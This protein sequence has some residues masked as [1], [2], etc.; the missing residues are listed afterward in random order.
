MSGISFT[1]SARRARAPPAAEV[2][3]TSPS[4]T[5][6]GNLPATKCPAAVCSRSYQN[7][8]DEE[9]RRLQHVR[10][11]TWLGLRE[12][13][14]LGQDVRADGPESRRRRKHPWRRAK[15]SAWLSTLSAWVVSPCLRVVRCGALA[16]WKH[17]GGGLLSLTLGLIAL[18]YVQ[19]LQLVGAIFT[20]GNADCLRDAHAVE[21]PYSSAALAG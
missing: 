20:G 15:F 10:L 2:A 18:P 19:R 3:A 17:L 4:V 8:E 7:C 1:H 5:D 11:L 12:D 14:R 21:Q 9:S 13:R 6:E 16:T